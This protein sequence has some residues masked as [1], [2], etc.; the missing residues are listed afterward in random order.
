MC[1]VPVVNSPG[2]VLP[3]S[4]ASSAELAKIETTEGTFLLCAVVLIFLIWVGKHVGNVERVDIKAEFGA[5]K[6][7]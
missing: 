2:C 6:K 1:P 4:N 7:R 5:K 3:K